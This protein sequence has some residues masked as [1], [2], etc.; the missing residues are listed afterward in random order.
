M[1]RWLDET[2]DE[3]ADRSRTAQSTAAARG[4]YEQTDEYR[5]A[6]ARSDRYRKVNTMA[7]D[8]DSD[9]IDDLQGQ[10]GAL[11]AG[12]SNDYGALNA[13]IADNTATLRA[14]LGMD[15]TH[16]ARA[17]AEKK[18]LEEDPYA[19]QEQELVGR[20]G[21]NA[22]STVERLK[23]ARA[24]LAGQKVDKTDAWL[25]FTQGAS[26]PNEGGKLAFAGNIAGAVRPAL[27]AQRKFRD[28]QQAGLDSYDEDI[29]KAQLGDAGIQLKLLQEKRKA[30]QDER[31]RAATIL[32]KTVP[33]GAGSGSGGSGAGGKKFD[34]SVAGDFLDWATK[35]GPVYDRSK[36]EL[37]AAIDRIKRAKAEGKN[38]SGRDVWTSYL[39]LFG[40]TG[41]KLEGLANPLASDIRNTVLNTVQQTLR[42]TL[43][44]A[45]T[46]REGQRV[47]SRAYDP[48]KPEEVNIA[49]IQA[50]LTQIQKQA[51]TSREVNEWFLANDGDMSGFK[52][53]N[54]EASQFESALYK[55]M[56]DAEASLGLA[57]RDQAPKKPPKYRREENGRIIPTAPGT[58]PPQRH[59]QRLPPEGQEA[60]PVK[61][62]DTT[63]P[64]K[65]E[66]TWKDYIGFAEGGIAHVDNAPTSRVIAL[67]ENGKPTGEIYAVPADMTDE[68][69]DEFIANEKAQRHEAS[70]ELG[71][72][73]L[74]A[75]AT[76]VGTGTAA[77]G[78]L[79]SGEALD[80]RMPWSA[81]K[82]DPGQRRTVDLANKEGFDFKD[83]ASRLR[84]MQGQL[85][86]P[87]TALD[88]Y[89]PEMRSLVNQAMRSPDG[90]DETARLQELL[91]K[92]N[93]DARANRLPAAVDKAT[94]ADEYTGLMDR[95]TSERGA[96]ADTMYSKA[97]ADTPHVKAA[98]VQAVINELSSSPAGKVALREANNNWKA[99]V[100]SGKAK[101]N[102]VTTGLQGMP[103]KYQL[104][105]LNLINSALY[106]AGSG[107][108]GMEK[109][110]VSSLR[111]PLNASL[112]A[113]TGGD[114]SSYRAARTEYANRSRGIENL[115]FG[116]NDYMKLPP[117]E[118][119]KFIDNLDFEQTDYL[120]SGVAEALNRELRG[121]AAKTN[122]ATALLE[123]PDKLQRLE[124]LLP[125]KD[126]KRLVMTLE[127]ES[128]VWDTSTEF[129]RKTESA[130]GK[131]RG[132]P[133]STTS[134]VSSAAKAV[135]GKTVRAINPF[136]WLYKASVPPTSAEDKTAR[137]LGGRESSDIVRTA[138]GT[139]AAELERLSKAA[140]RRRTRGGRSALVGALAAGAGTGAA[141]YKNIF[142]DEPEAEE[143]Q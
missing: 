58:E 94:A 56:D 109:M 28:D 127:N 136:A 12:L 119:K 52:M 30:W 129:G 9:E 86:I 47:L 46:E 83:A 29:E 132:A 111:D 35:N 116:L 53:D 100:R 22:Q 2:D 48:F 118:A 90:T 25:A 43:G 137:M 14:G 40:D 5:A 96:T 93:N 81:R 103:T 125:P 115:E 8:Y 31:L 68:E 141:L 18:L 23:A 17:W 66:K 98:N 7:S 59:W 142:K 102:P 37:E 84:T 26:M 75:L 85:G 112:D 32:G 80:E 82:L 89:S 143:Q 44:S 65:K 63:K 78:A 88:V 140:G 70:N 45:F 51:A 128:K 99:L 122:P 11:R 131:P 38:I 41:E 64:V 92:R 49:R 120:R 139:R 39:S 104:Q 6:R 105:Y 62:T 76:G 19:A 13:G 121:T 61:K 50:L 113:A 91:S 27:Q 15:T 74:G 67:D 69:L 101:G 106:K 95:L 130:R 77:A 3:F 10:L 42:P 123:N 20:Y 54:A 107:A 138:R 117:A 126:Y 34:Q 16:E 1:E 72:D 87:A 4:R 79:A 108:L 134:K 135:P 21:Q 110:D 57:P 36:I 60:A 33:G 55:A 114:K 124:M 73:A 133:V 97:Y 24:K 71:R